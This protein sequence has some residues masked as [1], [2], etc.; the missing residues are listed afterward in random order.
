MSPRPPRNKHE[1][2][3]N[4]WLDEN[5]VVMNLFVAFAKERVRTG[6]RFGIGALTERVRWELALPSDSGSR[7]YKINNNLRAYIAREL[8]RQVPEVSPFLETR[9]V[10]LRPWTVTQAAA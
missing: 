3:F 9:A 4:R 6:R 2:A 8:I 7:G 5:P 10:A 1:A